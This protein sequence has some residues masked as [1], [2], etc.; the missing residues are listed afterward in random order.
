MAYEDELLNR[1]MQEYPFVRKHN[2]MV[3]TNP[4][5]NRGFAETYPI[6]ETGAPLPEGGFNK[7]PALPLDRV[8][9]E[10]F[11]PE[12]FSHHDL[13]AE[14][15]HIDP[16]AN[17]TR[18]QLL[19]SWTPKQIKALKEHALDYQATLDEGR[20]HEDALKNATDSALRGYT[21]GQWP[22]EINQKLAYS[23]DQLKALNK[24][25]EYMKQSSD[26]KTGGLI[27]KPIKGGMKLI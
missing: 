18:E 11:K 23:K 13:A 10:V 9:V 4:S 20:S 1:A 26:K 21:V 17:K 7:H 5:E 6:G 14:M 22:E 16:M 19:K 25:K 27:E 3:V 24:L 12:K 8:G 2:P 15:L